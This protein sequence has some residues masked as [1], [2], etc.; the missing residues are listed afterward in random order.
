ML[1][2]SHSPFI[3]V[4]PF[5]RAAKSDQDGERFCCE[6]LMFAAPL[7]RHSHI[8]HHDVS[9]WSGAAECYSHRKGQPR[10]ALVDM[11]D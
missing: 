7:Y 8:P 4:S 11:R 9:C 2:L 10:F 6:D 5:G 3:Q 1:C